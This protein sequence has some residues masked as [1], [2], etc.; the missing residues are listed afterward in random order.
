MQTGRG[1]ATVTLTGM[2][3][4]F[5]EVALNDLAMQSDNATGAR[6]SREPK[7]LT[8]ADLLGGVLLD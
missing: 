1:L 4:S 6:L 3:T 5:V 2:V 8:A 7:R